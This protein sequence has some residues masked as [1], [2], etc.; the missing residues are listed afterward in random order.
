MIKVTKIKP[1]ALLSFDLDLE[2][3]RQQRTHGKI[4][5]VTPVKSLKIPPAM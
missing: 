4:I 2:N 1:M 5:P 3:P